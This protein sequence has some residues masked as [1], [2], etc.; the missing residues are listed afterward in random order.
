MT[1]QN[2]HIQMVETIVLWTC[3][4]VLW[5]IHNIAADTVL[6]W[7]LKLLSL[8]SVSMVICINWPKFKTTLNAYFDKKKS[9]KRKTNNGRRKN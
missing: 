1:G 9:G 7:A 4:A 6:E 3:S 2:N 5:V 8:L